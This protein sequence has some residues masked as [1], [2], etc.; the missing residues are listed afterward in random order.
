M[1]EL[2]EHLAKSRII[3]LY[4]NDFSHFIGVVYNNIRAALR[5]EATSITL[6]HTGFVDR[7]GDRIKGQ[8][9][10]PHDHMKKAEYAQL[11]QAHFDAFHK[12]L[13][14]DAII[15]KYLRVMLD[16]SDEL[17]CEFIRE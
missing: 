12:V 4:P 3:T 6:D 15:K 13:E 10:F 2:I 8:F 1:E 7:Q 5:H 11:V 17:T 9:R 16:T 14:R